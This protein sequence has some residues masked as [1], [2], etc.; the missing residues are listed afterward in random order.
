MKVKMTPGNHGW[1]P[2]STAP[3]LPASPMLRCPR[4]DGAADKNG[5]MQLIASSDGRFPAGESR[6]LDLSRYLVTIDCRRS[7]TPTIRRLNPLGSLGPRQLP[8][9]SPVQELK[10]KVQQAFPTIVQQIAII[11]VAAPNLDKHFYQSLLSWQ[12][13]KKTGFY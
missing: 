6:R 11:L 5:I 10:A 1:T 2:P 7:T 12:L 4:P 3:S 8:V 13:V 9:A